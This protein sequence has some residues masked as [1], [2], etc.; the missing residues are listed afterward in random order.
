MN[1][2][3][4]YQ[5][6]DASC[7]INCHDSFPSGLTMDT[8]SGWTNDTVAGGAPGCGSCHPGSS[9]VNPGYASTSHSAHGA[10]QGALVSGGPWPDCITCHPNVDYDLGHSGSLQ[11][12]NVSYSGGANGDC[13]TSNCHNQGSEVS[14]TWDNTTQLECNDCHYYA[15][16][17]VQGDNTTHAASLSAEHG[18]HFAAGYGCS[19][20]HTVQPDGDVSHISGTSLTDRATASMDEATVTAAAL[21]PQGSDPDA[22]NASCDN[23]ACH[24]PSNSN[25]VYAATWVTENSSCTLCHSAT[26]PGTGSH[27]E[28]LNASGTFG[29][30]T[31]GCTSCHP[32]HGATMDHRDGS[33]D[34]N[35]SYAASSCTTSTCHNN[36][37]GTAVPTPAW[38]TPSANCSICHS[39]SPTSEAHNE[40]L[41]YPGAGC[42]DCHVTQTNVTHIND[43]VNITGAVNYNGNTA[44]PAG[45]TAFGTCQTTICHNRSTGTDRSEA[46]DT[47]NALACDDCHYYEGPVTGTSVT[48][49]SNNAAHARSLQAAHNTHF[50]SQK[51]CVECH[52]VQA[53]WDTSHINNKT[54]LS[55]GSTALPNEATVT[56]TSMVYAQGPDTCTGGIGLGCHATGV[57]AWNDPT[58]TDECTECHT[59]NTPSVNPS[60]GLHAASALTVHDE[61]V[62]GGSG[63]GCEKCHN[64]NTSVSAAHQDGNLDNSGAVAYSWNTSNIAAG[65][66]R[67]TDD[68]AASCHS[69][70]GTWN[71]EWTGVTDAA[72]SY[73][74]DPS[75]NAVCENCHGVYGAWGIIG[76]TS[77]VN[78]STTND[79]N[80][81]V[82]ARNNHTECTMCHG[83]DDASSNY[84]TGTKHEN[85][86]ITMNSEVQYQN[87]DASCNINCHDS[88][89][90]GLTMDTNSGWTNDTVAGGAPGC[91]SCHPANSGVNPGYASTSHIAHNATQA[92]L[93]A[94]GPWPDCVTCHPNVDYDLGHSGSLQFA[95]VSYSGGANGDCTTSNCH[96]QG[97]EVSNTW[98]NTTQ[99]ECNDCH[100]YE[101]SITN[102]N[103]NAA[104]AASLSNRHDSHFDK[105]LACS[106]CHTVQPDGD[107]SHISG[108][109]LVERSN[110]V[111]GNAAVGG[112][113]GIGYS[114][115][116]CSSGISGVG[117][118]ASANTNPAWTA[119]SLTC[120]DCHTTQATGNGYDPYTGI[121]YQDA[122]FPNTMGHDGSFSGYTCTDCHNDPATG[123]DHA[124]NTF[125][126]PATATFSWSSANGLTLNT[127]AGANTT[128]D[129]CVATCHSDGGDWDRKWTSKAYSTSEALGND[130]CDACHGDGQ[131]TLATWNGLG[132]SH[133]AN[134]DGD[135]STEIIGN[136]TANGN[137]CGTCHGMGVTDEATTYTFSLDHEDTFLEMNGP[138][139]QNGSAGFDSSTGLCD[140]ACHSG[141]SNVN[142]DMPDSG[143]TIEFG[144][145]GSGTCDSC[146]G[147]TTNATYWPDG[148]ARPDRAGEHPAHIAALQAEA[149]FT[150]SD[151]DQQSMCAYCHN[152]SNGVGGG[153]HSDTAPA[154][155]GGFNRIWDGTADGGTAAVYT[156]GD[157]T[158]GNC[159]G[160]DCHAEGTTPANS[161]WY[162]GGSTDCTM[163]H[164][165]GSDS[166]L[167]DNADPGTGRHAEHLASNT[168]VPQ[169]CTSCH[170]AN[171]SAG[172]H[173]GHRSGG[174]SYGN[175]LTSYTAPDCSN[176]CH[177]VVPA[178]DGD[179][180]DANPLDCTHCHGTVPVTAI[181]GGANMPNTGLHDETPSTSG[182][183]HD[184]TLDSP[185]VGCDGCH[186]TN[187]SDSHLDG[188]KQTS[189]P[190]INF[191]AI[192]FVDGN[193][194]TCATSCHADGGAWARKWHENSDLTNGSECAGCHGD[195]TNG[196][197][198]GVSL[199]H[200]GTDADGD[201][202]NNHGGASEPCFQCHTYDSAETYYTWATQ[203]RDGNIQL[204]NAVGFTDLGATVGCSGCH[205]ANDP[206]PGTNDEQHEYTDVTSRWTRVL[207][208][209]QGVSCRGCH[210][211]GGNG[212]QVD[213]NSSHI[214]HN[215]TSPTFT[216]TDNF[217]TNCHDGH[218]GATNGEVIPIPT[219]SYSDPFGST[220]NM[221]NILGIDYTSAGHNGIGLGG[222][223]TDQVASIRGLTVEAQ[224]CWACH[225]SL[226]SPVSEWGLNTDT[227][228]SGTNYNFGSVS[229]SNWYSASW[230]SAAGFTYKNGNLTTGLASGGA[231]VHAANFGASGPGTDS[232][233]AIRCSYCHDVHSLN[234]ASRTTSSA[235]YSDSGTTAPYLRG[236]WRGNPYAEDGAPITGS[237]SY[238][239]N[240]DMFGRVPRG[241]TNDTL[242][243]GFFI[244][245]N[246]TNTPASMNWTLANSAG[247][248]VLCHSDNVDDMNQFGTASAGWNA[249]TG[250]VNGHANAVLGGTGTSSGNATN[251]F[252][253]S[254]RHSTGITYDRNGAGNPTQ[255]YM[256]ASGDRGYG[257]RSQTGENEGWN[258][259]PQMD[260]G[261]TNRPYGFNSYSWGANVDD[262]STQDQYHQFSCSKCHN[263]HASRL[264]RLMIT[265]CLDTNHNTW[266]DL[267]GVATIPGAGTANAS[268]SDNVSTENGGVTFSNSTSAQNC[269]R[270]KDSSFSNSLGDGWNNVTPW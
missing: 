175:S 218:A 201:I 208:A 149:G 243:G 30:N 6:A 104:H 238:Y 83:W 59:D 248:C 16:S 57:P 54:S 35:F 186:S 116:T 65:Y 228:G 207:Q 169:D 81:L 229:T 108:S 63:T 21:G 18:T 252:R 90:S 249:G 188:T 168:Y 94:G 127:N 181:G 220:L 23:V 124:D 101:A 213:H 128:D 73:T 120:T 251:I 158:N 259:N 38:N 109:T 250:Q 267:G 55:D 145:Y 217:C 3:V 153:G 51:Q 52:T 198:S 182:E 246:T 157:G 20:C 183:R 44:I 56:R 102:N 122:G 231:S 36:G 226:G 164:N 133:T 233:G 114:N 5:N 80:V 8:N 189:A 262:T 74:N 136:H 194:P 112:S 100:Y 177:D 173:T 180:L 67:G 129:T 146:H 176:A 255:A 12:A 75:T 19:D 26:D 258:L 151:A 214:D 85:N 41:A 184:Q 236:S 263:P 222:N 34:I 166:G 245:Q 78:P 22:G 76:S 206:N 225:D 9:G 40:H 64:N 130:R 32:N 27:D 10:T 253:E 43:A 244:D 89:P 192:G 179:W 210:N 152:D 211:S 230:T 118:H 196:W 135:G 93:V 68:C 45:S 193:P 110:A 91:G 105:Q 219:T 11:F 42:T 216:S 221:A 205:A 25:N 37:K 88:F 7:N 95:N 28:H 162:D 223:S 147:N 160:V 47:A 117:C 106:N 190:T 239:A 185:D 154:E 69:D 119:A 134:P 61:T 178:S 66:V 82:D 113:K 143:F 268:G 269:H 254:N 167:L 172:T 79:P 58:S 260:D 234:R 174:P 266:D 200:T 139:G 142:H 161:Q 62:P 24:D 123:T 202:L 203:H 50:D 257:F 264:P 103:N 71:R 2:D 265:N 46:W 126:T 132:T 163:C 13:T 49:S 232:V 99:L 1:S 138:T 240:N 31:I 60:S 125:D 115:P 159:A 86:F 237:T 212:P 15:A 4:Q 77:H 137:E 97:S 121:H 48:D 261:G 227:N 14:N 141:A 209:G 247:L 215:G 17:P 256:N 204:D 92:D 33:N 270:V 171:A 107:V 144:Q 156:P 242:S 165:D 199:R 197:V 187:P 29:I 111:F 53:L 148:G 72:W 131:G 87:A 195:F 70:G 235:T 84:Q 98:D 155:V 140:A 241:G 170:G 191:A 39:D 96:N 224:I 150:T